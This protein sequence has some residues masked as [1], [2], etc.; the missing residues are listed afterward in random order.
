MNNLLLK[1][2][3]ENA[4]IGIIGLGYVGLP[5]SITF[6]RKFD[7]IGY[8]I[9][10]N[11][12]ES[13]KSGISTVQDISDEILCKYVSNTFFPTNDYNDLKNCDF[14][15][16]C[17]PTPLTYEKEPDLSYIKS[18]C[19]MIAKILRKRQFVILESTT[20]PGTT[21]DVVVPLL[22]RTGLTAGVDFG[23][24]YSPERVDP[25]NKTYTV[26]NTP[27]V[28]GGINELCTH[29]ASELYMS[30][31][32]ADI[33]R[34]K[35]CKTAEATKIFENIFR[36]VNIALVNEMALIC[37][38]MDI[39]IWE[40]IDAAS[41]KPF[42]FMP[43]YPGPGVGGHCIPLD[44]WYMSYKAKKL[45]IIPRFIETSG[46]IND[47][48][49]IH[50]VNLVEEGLLQIG[51][52]ILNSKI[53]ILGLAYKKDID[54]IRESPAKKIIEEIVNRAGDVKVYDPYVESIKTNAGMFYSEKSINDTL[55]SVDC[56]IFVVDHNVFK[57][58][59][60]G[61]ME[62]LMN[63]FVVVDCKNLFDEILEDCVYLCI[64]KGS[65]GDSNKQG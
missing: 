65:K 30:I 60:M 23:V 37:E 56:A 57:E 6:A 43:F 22:E 63:S 13:L 49:K 32:N 19:T 61:Q 54:D 40:M 33:V 10:E 25:G 38:K 62:K 34:V 29:I 51:K 55:M 52:K 45:G 27:K 7:V 21:D 15:I 16:I 24:A 26:E 39:D 58:M 5:L 48:M 1:I 35:D 9:N 17:V 31:I 42:G 41:T 18:A 11:I 36:N 53:A 50:A 4:R 64:G 28:V 8:D 14:I 44:P 2:E 59:E 20:Y 46:E 12:V 47:F 3:N